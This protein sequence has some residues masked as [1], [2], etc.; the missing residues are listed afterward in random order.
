MIYLTLRLAVKKDALFYYNIDFLAGTRYA[1]S[2]LKTSLFLLICSILVSLL[3]A[4]LFYIY[5]GKYVL[6]ITI[7]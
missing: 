3:I 7:T 6:I 4:F 2:T 1:I 5:T